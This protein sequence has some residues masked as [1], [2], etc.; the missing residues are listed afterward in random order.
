MKSVIDLLVVHPPFSGDPESRK[1]ERIT[2]ALFQVLSAPASMVMAAV[3][4]VVVVAA[5]PTSEARRWPARI[6]RLKERVRA[7]TGTPAQIVER[8]SVLGRMSPHQG[9]RGLVA[10]DRRVLG[11]TCR[12][13]LPAW[14]GPAGRVGPGD[15]TDLARRSLSARSALGRVGQI[16]Q[17]LPQVREL[18]SQTAQ[19]FQ[20]ERRQGGQPV[21]AARRQAQA[22][23]AMVVVVPH[24]P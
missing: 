4:A 7:R 11:V 9:V 15:L 5:T 6:E 24:A 2:D 14:S 10:E 1:Q 18:P 12:L 19:L 16:G 17:A 23:H 8:G 3:A 21:L 20:V 22:D 13:C